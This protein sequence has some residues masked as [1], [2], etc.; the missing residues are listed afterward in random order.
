MTVQLRQEDLTWQELD[1]ETIVLDLQT[2][3]Y[4]VINKT[5]TLLWRLLAN[6]ATADDLAAELIAAYNLSPTVARAHAEEFIEGLR[7]SGLLQ[8]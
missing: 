5:G 1:D 4:F 7:R 6:E 8:Q 2:S 3:K